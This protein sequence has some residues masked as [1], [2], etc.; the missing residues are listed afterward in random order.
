[1]VGLDISEPLIHIG[2]NK[3]P[4][5]NLI[6]WDKKTLPFRSLSLDAALFECAL[7]VMGFS[8]RLLD[9]CYDT[10][11]INGNLIISDIF[12]K[13]ETHNSFLP[14]FTWLESRLVAS[15]FTIETS[16]DHTPALITYVA[17]L[18]EQC[19][20]TSEV[21]QL[22]CTSYAGGFKVSDHCYRLIIARKI[23]R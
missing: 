12:A 18:S 8:E 7:S 9:E 14:T 21:N 15:G 2:L 5:L 19:G 10:L 22:L 13:Q 4:G 3:N 23:E 6:H 1:M 11:M 20:G 16:E 17:E